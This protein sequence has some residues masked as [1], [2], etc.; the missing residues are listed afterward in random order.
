MEDRGYQLGNLDATIIAQKPKL[1]PFKEQIRNNL[2]SLL[3][4]HPS[5]IN[6]KVS[7]SMPEVHAAHGW[8]LVFQV[9]FQ[10]ALRTRCQTLIL[11]SILKAAS[12]GLPPFGLLV[13]ECQASGNTCA[14][15]T[16]D[17]KDM[18]S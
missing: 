14:L 7:S 5:V 4:A 10:S 17:V 11:A 18:C 16:S 15:K 2:A 6:L 13:D 1:S 3:G 8:L 9:Q 12:A